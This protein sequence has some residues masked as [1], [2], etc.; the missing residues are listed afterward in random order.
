MSGF[1][2]IELAVV[3]VI[4]SLVTAVAVPRLTQGNGHDQPTAAAV[5]ALHAA[6]ARAI[7]SGSHV[8]VEIG[9]AVF[10]FSPTGAVASDTLNIG[11]GAAVQRV[12]ADR[13]SGDVQVR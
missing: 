12:F 5:N 10:R 8:T 6:R 13:W 2:L 4:I 11:N 3:L 7:A 1:T 9:G